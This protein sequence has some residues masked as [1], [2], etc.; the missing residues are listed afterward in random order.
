MKV[1]LTSL[2]IVA[3]I[4]VG[5]G[6]VFAKFLG[7]WQG[8]VAALIIQF[9]IFYIFTSSQSASEETNT[10]EDQLVAL[11]TA[12]ITCPCGKHVF[13]APVFLNAENLFT[14]EKCGSKFRVEMSYDSVV[15]T[16]P[17]NIENVFNHLKEKGT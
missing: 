12:P 1:L 2:A 9:L 13:S 17:L 5:V 15:L 7:F 10:V 4:S 14:C 6:F 11:Q 3:T 16:E 8:A